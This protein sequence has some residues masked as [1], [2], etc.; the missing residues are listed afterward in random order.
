MAGN[1]LDFGITLYWT[2]LC[3]HSMK[4]VL[5]SRGKLHGANKGS[6]PLTPA[7]SPA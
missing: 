5:Y 3:R 4:Q 1:D 6:K 2:S 7:A